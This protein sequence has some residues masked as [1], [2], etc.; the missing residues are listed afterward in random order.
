MRGISGKRI[1]KTLDPD[2]KASPETAF[3]PDAFRMDALS[4]Y[5]IAGTVRCN[6][7]RAEVARPVNLIVADHIMRLAARTPIPDRRPY[8]DTSVSSLQ[9]PTSGL[10]GRYDLRPAATTTLMSGCAKLFRDVEDPI[11]KHFGDAINELRPDD[12]DF[13]HITSP[14]ARRLFAMVYETNRSL[15]KS[16]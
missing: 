1:P 3:S 14:L 8:A 11:L 2:P 10:K 15:P 16:K 7:A 9:A 6:L 5:S 4:R 12:V 13:R